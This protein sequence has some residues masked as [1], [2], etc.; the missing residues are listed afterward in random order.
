MLDYCIF[1]RHFSS[2]SCLSLMHA[3]VD[4]LIQNLFEKKNVF[5]TNLQVENRH[6]VDAS[7]E[8]EQCALARY[9]VHVR[10]NQIVCID[11]KLGVCGFLQCSSAS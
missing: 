4:S 9:L 11:S 3:F 6:I 7:V 10:N 1:S 2:Q 8:E 5:Y